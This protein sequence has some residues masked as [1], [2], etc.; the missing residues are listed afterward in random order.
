MRM[1]FFAMQNAFPIVD[2]IAPDTEAEE[3]A[4]P[5]IDINHCTMR[6]YSKR[7]S[8]LAVLAGSIRNDLA[9]FG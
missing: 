4:T 9:A 5:W 6:H 1:N 3:R 7:H 8:P 2:P